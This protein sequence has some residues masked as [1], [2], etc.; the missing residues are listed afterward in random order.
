MEAL[1][2]LRRMMR[3]RNWDRYKLSANEEKR[4]ETGEKNCFHDNIGSRVLTR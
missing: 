1:Y 3:D 4:Q 2:C